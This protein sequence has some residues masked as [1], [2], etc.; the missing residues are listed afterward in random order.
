M[1]AILHTD[2][3]WGIGKDNDLMFQLKKDM[4]FF[5]AQTTN[6]VVVMGSNTLLSLPNS[7]PLPKRTNIVLYPEGKERDDCVIVQS[8]S[9]L[10]KEL[11]KYN[12][13]EIYIIGGAMFYRTMLPYCNE[14]LVTKV[15]AVG[16][17]DTYFPNLDEMSEWSC[18]SESE[19]QED[20]DYKIKFCT[21]SNAEIKE[22]R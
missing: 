11:A 8:M 14:V 20:G 13:D 15:Q 21:Y 12:E 5:R 2:A 17:A 7:K 16:N 19:E 22:Y 1:K 9:E 6:K 10:F 18:V 4:A 3:N